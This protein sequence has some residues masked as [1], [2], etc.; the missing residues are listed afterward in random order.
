MMLLS[1]RTRA[2]EVK[3]HMNKDNW[4]CYGHE[5]WQMRFL[6]TRTNANEVHKYKIKGQKMLSSTQTTLIE[7][8][9]HTNKRK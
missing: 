2:N 5:Q 8:V 3:K 7:V 6:R 4:D 9:K 1:T